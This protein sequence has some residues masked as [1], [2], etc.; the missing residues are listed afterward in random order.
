MKNEFSID[1]Q[2]IVSSIQLVKLSS[3]KPIEKVMPTHLEY[4]SSQIEQTGYINKPLII[5]KT[6]NII[7]DGSHR[8]AYLKS[9]GYLFAP[10]LVVNYDSSLI[11]VGSNLIHRYINKK[12]STI[13]KDDVIKKAL[14]NE[15]FNPRTTRHFFPFKKSDCPTTLDKLKRGQKSC[16]R[17]LLSDITVEE[18][19]IYN[20]NYIK[21]IDNE[22]SLI[23]QY[24]Q[25]QLQTKEYLQNQIKNM[26]NS[27]NHP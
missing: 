13:T 12:Q 25:E 6:N 24:T 7:L 17:H 10:V 2:N 20:K 15:L 9:Q 27:I 19:I 11:D 8:Y 18:E 1:T 3:L 21:E 4:I 22:L 14:S 5:D 23:N 16:I 26:Q